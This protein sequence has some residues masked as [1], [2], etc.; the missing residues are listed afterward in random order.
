M[1]EAGIQPGLFRDLYVSLGERLDDTGAWSVRIHVKPFVRWI[2]MGA[3]FMAIG[4]F[5]AATDKRLRSTSQ[6]RGRVA[7]ANMATESR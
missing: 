2:W 4:G 5:L 1:T 6:V 3:I 7:A